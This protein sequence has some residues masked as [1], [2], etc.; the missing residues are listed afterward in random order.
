MRTIHRI[1]LIFQPIFIIF[2]SRQSSPTREKRNSCPH[3]Y[4][5]V[6]DDVTLYAPVPNALPHFET[7]RIQPRANTERSRSPTYL[8]CPSSFTGAR[9][10]QIPFI[11]YLELVCYNK[12]SK[13]LSRNCCSRL[14]VLVCIC[15]V[16]VCAYARVCI[17]G[18]ALEMCRTLYSCLYESLSCFP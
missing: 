1:L 14:R 11:R 5:S 18:C 17:M 15:N 13:H 3:A 16:C 7:E 8:R 10:V 2:V 12:M 4:G 9:K 6:D